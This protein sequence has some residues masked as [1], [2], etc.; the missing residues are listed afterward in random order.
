M[1]ERTQPAS[2]EW[3][4]AA[5]AASNFPQPAASAALV[6]FSNV[7]SRFLNAYIKG[8]TAFSPGNELDEWVAAHEQGINLNGQ[9]KE[10]ITPETALE[11]VTVF[12]R[13]GDNIFKKIPTNDKDNLIGGL[14]K[15]CLAG[16]I[17][18]AKES[19][20]GKFK[21]AVIG[22]A[23]SLESKYSSSVH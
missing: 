13:L 5:R 22:L 12:Q 1:A 8:G 10:R 17:M 4:F 20:D 2:L 15:N 23:E 6:S 11:L 3:Y 18:Y 7:F 14:Y 21:Q 19:K 16:L 9:L